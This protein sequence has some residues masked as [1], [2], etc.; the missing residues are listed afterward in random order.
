[1]SSSKAIKN[2]V[3]PES[4]DP[5]DSDE[6]LD[7]L[8]EEDVDKLLKEPV[9]AKYFKRCKGAFEQAL[10]TKYKN[11]PKQK[12]VSRNIQENRR[13][14]S[15]T[16]LPNAEEEEQEEGEGN[17]TSHL[18][19]SPNSTK[20]TRKRKRGA[21]NPTG[22]RSD[23]QDQA[24]A[25]TG[26]ATL[27]TQT[28]PKKKRRRTKSEIAADMLPIAPRSLVSKLLVGAHVSA[29][30]GVH[31]AVLN[32]VQIGGNAMALFLKSQRK[33]ENPP[34]KEE[35]CQQFLSYCREH[36]YNGDSEAETGVKNNGAGVPS[37]VPHGSYL[38]NLAQAAD[39]RA[40]QAYDSFIDDL[41]RCRRLGIKLYNFHPGNSASSASRAAA[42]KTLAGHMNR[43]HGDPKS[44]SVVT[45]LET[46]AGAANTLG[47][48]FEDLRD[49]IDLIDNKTRVGVCLDTCHVF[50]A[51]YDIRTP[52]TLADTLEKFDEVVGLKYLM[53]LHLNDSKAPLGSA[54]DLHANIGT[55]FLGLRA[56]HALVNES[57]LWG[58][59][60]V[61]ETPIE[62]KDANG[63]EKMEKSIWA[64]EIKLLESLVG[65]DTESEGFKKLENE[66]SVKGSSERQRIQDQVK[67]RDEKAAKEAARKATGKGKRKGKAKEVVTMEE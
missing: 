30:G 43:A 58:L 23:E 12:L 40:K 39:V 3:V 42:I 21:A 54:R 50:A 2:A 41:D 47:S 61:L 4:I 52:E 35:H 15:A 9:V 16:T 14:G 55:G 44:G 65:M 20:K 32:S 27:D 13:G 66:L 57:R 17:T 33:W 31:N 53:A 29:A 1:M 67:R 34:L 5:N 36:K 63:K 56:F 62:V 8:D 37:I 51:G 26:D 10:D 45:L 48:T 38:V 24:E 6:D 59:P 11:R 60:M 7:S 18:E 49:I 64:N 25:E 22:G 19:S 28:T 46:M